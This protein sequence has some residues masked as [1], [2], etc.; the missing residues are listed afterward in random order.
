M[1]LSGVAAGGHHFIA[2]PLCR[3]VSDKDGCKHIHLNVPKL[4]QSINMGLFAIPSDI[5]HSAADL[6]RRKSLQEDIAGPL[7]IIM[8]P[9]AGGVIED[10]HKISLRRHPK[11]LLDLLPGGHQ[12]AEADQDK[13]S[14]R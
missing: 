1:P 8:P 11:L 12:V 7:Q 2:D 13:T 14:G 9:F 3:L 10:D 5:A 4:S 6:F